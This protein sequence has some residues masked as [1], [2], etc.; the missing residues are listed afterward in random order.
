MCLAVHF[1]ILYN[2]DQIIEINVSTDSNQLVDIS[3][4][5]TSQVE[6]QRIPAEFTYRYTPSAT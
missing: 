4:D 2:G 1:E 5:V 3:P 6:G